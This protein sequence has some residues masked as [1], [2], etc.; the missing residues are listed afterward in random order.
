VQF[1]VTF[2][3]A[4]RASFFLVAIFAW[5]E[6]AGE[7]NRYRGAFYS[8]DE[9]ATIAFFSLACVLALFWAE[10]Y[11]IAIDQVR[12]Y[13]YLIRPMT[14]AINVGAYIAVIGCAY[15]AVHSSNDTSAYIYWNF[16]LLVAILFVLSAL[17]FTFFAYKAATEI[18]SIPV[19]MSTR[20]ERTEELSRIFTIFILAL[21]ARAA[22]LLLMSNDD[23][24][25]DTSL[26]IVLVAAY[27]VLLELVPAIFAIVFYR[28]LAGQG[29]SGHFAVYG[30][31]THYGD[32][33]ASLEEFQP[34]S[35]PPV[36]SDVT[37]GGASGKFAAPTRSATGRPTATG[38]FED[39]MAVAALLKRLNVAPNAA[40]S[41][42]SP[43]TASQSHGN[44]A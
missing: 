15:A 10:V 26:G 17:V 27:F 28:T 2:L 36:A 21:V 25:T 8:L 18:S 7:V 20:Q 37:I 34:L 23:L 29:D 30:Q 19:H 31:K 9:L 33:H 5:D 1:V 41:T 32:T 35:A 22:C 3:T 12:E 44:A 13:R 40:S 42:P 4:T 38:R 6:S 14:Y 24:I 43:S 11:Y 39:D 16:S